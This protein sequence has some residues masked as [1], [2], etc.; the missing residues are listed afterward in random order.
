MEERKKEIDD[1]PKYFHPRIA[2][3]S[4]ALRLSTKSEQ[5]LSMAIRP[6]Q[7]VRRLAKLRETTFTVG[8]RRLC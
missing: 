3:S 5:L 6:S 8:V 4:F 2:R 1:G 7:A